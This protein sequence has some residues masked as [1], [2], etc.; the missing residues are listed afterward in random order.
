MDRTAPA[1]RNSSMAQGGGPQQRGQGKSVRVA[2]GPQVDEYIP[3][4]NDA[5]S[6]SAP[7]QQRPRTTVVEQ[8]Q[9]NVR[10]NASQAPSNSADGNTGTVSP[11]VTRNIRPT[12][13]L[14]RA[15]S[16]HYPRFSL[17]NGV[18]NGD[19]EDFQLRH[20]WH[21]E[22][23][24]SEYLKILNSVSNNITC[25]FLALGGFLIIASP[26]A[27]IC[28]SPRNGMKPLAY[29][30]TQLGAGRAKIGV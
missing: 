8:L 20:G 24:S 13:T 22:Y 15:K 30:R 25:L 23:T 9:S 17:E 28:I 14:V 16:E 5:P 26:R 29:R 4:S 11:V 12:P 19:G 3:P 10:P 7:G 2:F 18:P 27:F 6:P 21:E 1:Q